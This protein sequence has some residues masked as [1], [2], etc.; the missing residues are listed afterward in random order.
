MGALITFILRRARALGSSPGR[1]RTFGDHLSS[2]LCFILALLCLV[3]SVT[4]AFIPDQTILVWAIRLYSPDGVISAEARQLALAVLSKS[5]MASMAGA[6]L[7][8]GAGFILRYA[9]N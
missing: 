9:E 4:L 6:V 3:A 5:R 7:G 8:L 2:K 1:Q